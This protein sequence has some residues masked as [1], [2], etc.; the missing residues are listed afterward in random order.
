M[1]KQTPPTSPSPASNVPT[2]APIPPEIKPQRSY[3]LPL[4]IISGL[5]ILL[6]IFAVLTF[7][8]FDRGQDYSSLYSG[9]LESGEIRN[10]VQEIIEKQTPSFSNDSNENATDTVQNFTDVIQNFTEEES[11]DFNLKLIE[12]LLVLLKAYNLDE[13]KSEVPKIQ[14]YLDEMPYFIEII[15][16]E[17]QIE[18]GIMEGEDIIIGTIQEELIK[19]T[20]DQEYIKTSFESGGS[21]IELIGEDIEL[22]M[23]GYLEIYNEIND[24][25]ATGNIILILRD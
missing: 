21:T 18:E 11:K 25:G 13:Y 1:D 4:V 15:G 12:Y 14:F 20:S 3:N 6:A 24:N 16:G 9:R 5:A 22:F 2:K 23:K 17:I 7:F 19:M 10:P 8:I